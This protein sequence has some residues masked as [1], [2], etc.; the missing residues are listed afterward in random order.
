[1]LSV[2]LS[3]LARRK[4]QAAVAAVASCSSVV[5]HPAL[6]CRCTSSLPSCNSSSSWFNVGTLRAAAAAANVSSKDDSPLP[7]IAT[8]TLSQRETMFE[9]REEIR[10]GDDPKKAARAGRR[11]AVLIPLCLREGEP[12]VLFTVRSQHVSTHKG[13]VS[14]RAAPR[15]QSAHEGPLLTRNLHFGYR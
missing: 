9:V 11:A 3:H 12:A 5:N 7:W 8:T 13:Q 4:T 6:C 1:M 10:R 15:G 14:I 2:L